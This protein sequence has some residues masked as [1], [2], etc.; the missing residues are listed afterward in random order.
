MVIPRRGTLGLH[1][2]T[3]ILSRN[4]LKPGVRHLFVYWPCLIQTPSAVFRHSLLQTLL[5]TL[6][7]LMDVLVTALVNSLGVCYW[8]VKQRNGGK[9]GCKCCNRRNNGS[10]RRKM[11]PPHP[12]PALYEHD[13][14]AACNKSSRDFINYK[15]A[16]LPW[17]GALAVILR[18]VKAQLIGV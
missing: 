7:W 17:W 15:S 4:G 5:I 11:T 1:G 2:D 14:S 12:S 18:Y 3:S 13:G 16:G 10:T 6:V 8:V 9:C